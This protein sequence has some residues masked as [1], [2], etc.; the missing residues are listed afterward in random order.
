[1][2]KIGVVGN[3]GAWSSEQLADEVE[4]QTGFRCLV[5]LKHVRLDFDGQRVTYQDVDLLQ[6]DALM[7]KKIGSTYAPQHLDRLEILRYVDE[8]GVLVVSRPESII[9]VLNR[10]TCTVTLQAGGIPMPPTAITEDV[11]EALAVV[12]RFGRAVFKPLF[13]TKARGME[14]VEA[15]AGARDRIAAFQDAGHPVMYIQ[16]LKELPDR[17]LGVSFLGG[18]YLGTYARVRTNGETWNTTT[19]SGGHYEQAEPSDEVI[20]LA[21]RAQ[22]LFDLEFTSVDV[23]ECADGPVVFE[24]S[25]FGG[26]RGLR[27]GCGIDA[28]AVYTEHVLE[29][30][31]R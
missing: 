27:D 3:K 24:V 23:A 15:D 1:M 19:R 20:E 25:A 10:L 30:I 26:F 12:Q 17:D 11:D 18:E 21:R 28:A 7:V 13:S 14:L 6:L 4:R 29:R 5:D 2:I 16:Q 22:A 31:G 9:R 8:R